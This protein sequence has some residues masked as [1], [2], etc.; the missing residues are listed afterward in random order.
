M[1][2]KSD[3]WGNQQNYV[4]AGNGTAS[5]EYADNEAGE[6][7]HFT[8]FQKPKTLNKDIKVDIKTDDTQKN[9]KPLKNRE[10]N[11][12]FVE[13]HSTFKKNDKE[14]I[15]QIINNADDKIIDSL[16]IAYQKGYVEFRIGRG[17]YAYGGLV[18]TEKQD[19]DNYGRFGIMGEVWFHENGHLFDNKMAESRKDYLSDTYKNSEGFSLN[20][21]ATKEL[22]EFMDNKTYKEIINTK[23]NYIE[24]E[25]KE[26]NN[27]RFDELSAK[28]EKINKD[29]SEAKKKYLSMFYEDKITFDEYRK[30]SDKIETEFQS[31]L[32][33]K[34]LKELSDLRKEKSELTKKATDKFYIDYATI[35]DLYSSSGV[36]YGFGVGHTANY[37]RKDK[38]NRGI[39]LFA[40]LFS[41]KAV[42]KKSYE[43]TKKYFPQSVKMFEEILANYGR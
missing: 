38:R 22:K 8:N 33:D 36:S 31:S 14:K 19:L 11:I 16:N 12:K 3:R 2:T 24:N 9:N 29:K 30:F 40:N 5:G 43:M 6:N 27:N 32:S 26:F 1:P 41:N 20:D 39:E 21:I 25:L 35:S 42:N 15:N 10:D 17:I 37:Y 18:K 34:E 23:L 13:E 4:P 7:K 28:V